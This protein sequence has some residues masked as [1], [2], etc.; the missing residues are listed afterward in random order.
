MSTNGF[1]Y[2]YDANDFGGLVDT[3]LT[4]KTT[5]RVTWKLSYAANGFSATDYEVDEAV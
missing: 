2:A 3:A 4:A 1:T 5:M